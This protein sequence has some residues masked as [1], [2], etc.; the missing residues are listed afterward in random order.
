MV[1]SLYALE[2]FY[3]IPVR[4]GQGTIVAEFDP[5]APA[6]KDK[7]NAVVAKAIVRNRK[8]RRCAH[9]EDVWDGDPQRLFP[10]VEREIL[11]FTKLYTGPEEES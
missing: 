7:S 2:A 3:E 1:S 5:A 9:E 10:F 8:R 4:D 6:N 11:E